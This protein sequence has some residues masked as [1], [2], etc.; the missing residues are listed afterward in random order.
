[1]SINSK[2][3]KVLSQFELIRIF[4]S[5]LEYREKEMQ[6]LGSIIVTHAGKYNNNYAEAR[7]HRSNSCRISTI[8]MQGLG[9]TGI[10]GAGAFQ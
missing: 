3:I 7:E 2:Y 6:R 8:I 10:T 1:M 4:K 9:S 5:S